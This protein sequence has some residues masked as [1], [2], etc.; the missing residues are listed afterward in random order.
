ME[1]FVVKFYEIIVGI[2]SSEEKA[3]DGMKVS[4]DNFGRY[5]LEKYSLDKTEEI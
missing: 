2:Y 3:K 5:Q 1:L 4:E